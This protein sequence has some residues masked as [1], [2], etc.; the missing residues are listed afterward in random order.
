MARRVNYSYERSQ[1]DR[2]KVEKREAKRAARSARKDGVTEDQTAPDA[3]NMESDPAAVG[4]AP[5][6]ASTAEAPASDDTT[7]P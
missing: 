2:A 5:E 4:T 1:R 3:P 7:Q 6:A